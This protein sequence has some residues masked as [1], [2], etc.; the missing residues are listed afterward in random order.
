[1]NATQIILDLGKI[2]QSKCALCGKVAKRA[3]G[4]TIHH[5]DYDG[6]HGLVTYKNYVKKYGRKYKDPYYRALAPLVRKTP[7]SFAFVHNKCH[8]AIERLK[9]WSKDNRMR[10]CELAERTKT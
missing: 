9:R 2:Y 10:L 6:K 7:T 5:F 3:K 8:Q 1:M 4:F